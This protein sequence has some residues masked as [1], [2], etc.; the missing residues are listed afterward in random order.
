MEYSII[1]LYDSMYGHGQCSGLYRRWFVHVGSVS[2]YK[3]S[4]GS[5]YGVCNKLS[6]RGLWI[7]M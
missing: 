1:S 2:V 6:V 7:G 5:L 3:G 4:Y